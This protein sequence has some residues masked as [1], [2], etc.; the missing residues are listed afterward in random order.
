MSP[1][2]K[3]MD[4]EFLDISGS[5][6]DGYIQ[7]DLFTFVEANTEDWIYFQPGNKV[8]HAHIDLTRTT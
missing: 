2:G 1:D 7:R 3:I 8:V 6:Q 4:I 5:T